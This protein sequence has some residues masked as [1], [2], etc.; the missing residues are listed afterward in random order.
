MA[1]SNWDTFALNHKGE[2]S[3]GSFE[4]HGT[5]AEI[6]K[7]WIYIRDPQMWREGLSY[8]EPTIMELNE[9]DLTIGKLHIRAVRGPKSGIYAVVWT[10]HEHDDSI[11]GMVGIGC[12]GFD[13]EGEWVGADD[14]E[15][16]FFKGKLTEWAS[17]YEIPKLFAELDLQQGQRFNQGDAFFGKALGTE[18]PTTEP[19]EGE[20]P[21][22]IQALKEK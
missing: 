8:V 18:I 22:L 9:G 19:G 15:V 17:E 14:A 21:L 5:S 10:G 3:D 20:E 7:N 12:Y 1:L 16:E 2:A 6:Y 13:E 4:S 11:Q